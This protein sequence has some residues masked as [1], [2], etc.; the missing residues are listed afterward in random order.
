MPRG[1]LNYLYGV[2]LLGFL[3]PVI[4]ICLVHSPYLADLK[5]FECVHTHLLAKVDSTAEAISRTS[6]DI[7]HILTSK[8]PFL[9]LCSLRGLLTMRMRNMWSGQGLAASLNCPALLLLEFRSTGN[10]SPI[11]LPWGSGGPNLPPASL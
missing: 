1:S 4:L 9:H 2:F 8:E 7:T 3:W 11:T 6:L 5:I 10:E